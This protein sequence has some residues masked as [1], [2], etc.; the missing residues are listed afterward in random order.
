MTQEDNLFYCFVETLAILSLFFKKASAM[1][2]GHIRVTRI[3][4]ARNSEGT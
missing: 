3:H 2:L 1:S 4:G